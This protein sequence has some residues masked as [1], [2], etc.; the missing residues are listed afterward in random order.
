MNSSLLRNLFLLAAL[1]TLGGCK[2]GLQQTVTS[3]RHSDFDLAPASRPDVEKSYAILHRWLA[4]NGFTKLSSSGDI[5]DA[6]RWSGNSSEFSE[7]YKKEIAPGFPQSFFTVT[8]LDNAEAKFLRITL[9]SSVVGNRANQA[10]QES[11]V[12]S[13]EAKFQGAFRASAPTNTP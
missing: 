11:L 3:V 13:E 7:V 10:R 12:R 8:V 4:E 5:K 1:F 6:T 2:F 9:T